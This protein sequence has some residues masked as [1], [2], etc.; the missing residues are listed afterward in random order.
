MV[1]LQRA[2]HIPDTIGCAIALADIRITQGRLREAMNIY[3]HGLQLATEQGAFVL[4]GAT[5][6][7]V[8]MSALHRERN[9]L[10]TATGHLLK[11]Q[12]L[13]QHTGLPQNLYRWRVAMARI[14]GLKVI[15]MVLSNCSMKQ[16][17]LYV[18][19]YFP[20]VCPIAAL[21]ARM[22]I[23]QGRLGEALGWVREQGLFVGDDLSYIR[24]FEHITLTRLLLAQY[25][26]GHEDHLI[27]DAM[28]LLER[29][30]KAANEVE[31]WKY[32]RNPDPASARPPDAGRHPCRS[33]AAG[34]RLEIG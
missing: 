1:L 31:N 20:N 2:G 10:N 8:G 16:K 3:Q 11:S 9:D 7:Y 29:L 13:G 27:L 19:D 28:G 30:L 17:R 12:E 34:T 26:S 21:R 18:S 25:K 4:R 5:D 14:R 32:D 24:E 15:W 6:M 22:W 23:A 33:C